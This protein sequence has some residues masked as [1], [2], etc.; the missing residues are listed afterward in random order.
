MVK[1]AKYKIMSIW[2]NITCPNFELQ[3]AA[4]KVKKAQLVTMRRVLL[5][6]WL[7]QCLLRH[8]ISFYCSAASFVLVL[9]FRIQ[10]YVNTKQNIIANFT[11]YLIICFNFCA[12]ENHGV[13]VSM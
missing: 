1:N 9:F 10:F 6:T 7:G 3:N 12:E 2:I 5:M 13:S 8:Y 4:V 11:G